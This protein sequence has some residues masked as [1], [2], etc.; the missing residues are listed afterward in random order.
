[1]SHKRYNAYNPL[2]TPNELWSLITS[3]LTLADR[4]L[5]QV[6]RMNEQLKHLESERSRTARRAGPFG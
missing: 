1:M 2:A 4:L 5:D 3:P 6:G